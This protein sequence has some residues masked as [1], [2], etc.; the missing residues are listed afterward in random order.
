MTLT[1]WVDVGPNRE[2]GGHLKIEPSGPPKIL[3]ADSSRRKGHRVGLGAGDVAVRA[4]FRGLLALVV[5]DFVI[6]SPVVS[7]SQ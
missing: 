4:G 6:L 3:G 7:V 1:S 2:K 5:G